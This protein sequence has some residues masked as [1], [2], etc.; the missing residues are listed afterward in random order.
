MKLYVNLPKYERNV[1]WKREDTWKVNNKMVE[2]GTSTSTQIEGKE[3]LSE[4][5]KERK[6]YAQAT[7]RKNG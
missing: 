6:S 3:A 5:R 4:K 1:T 2:K 7:A